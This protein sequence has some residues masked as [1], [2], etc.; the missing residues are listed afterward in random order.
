MPVA[1]GALWYPRE[2]VGWYPKWQRHRDRGSWK[3]LM[4]EGDVPVVI[5]SHV[6][7]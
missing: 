6:K 3:W 2:A 1:T 5:A 7:S 4:K